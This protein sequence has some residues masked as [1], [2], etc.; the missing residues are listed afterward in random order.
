MSTSQGGILKQE[1]LDSLLKEHEDSYPEEW[2]CWLLNGPPN[3][4]ASPQQVAHFHIPIADPV[5][6]RPKRDK[7]VGTSRKAVTLSEM[8]AKGYEKPEAHLKVKATRELGHSLGIANAL[9][10][11]DFDLKAHT[12]KIANLEKLIDITD[13]PE[14]KKE[15]KAELKLLYRLEIDES[16]GM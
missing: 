6:E 13:T 9:A 15:L 8:K 12:S 5:D 2:A 4:S 7:P 1:E 16:V 3:L 10:A 14:S 11:Q